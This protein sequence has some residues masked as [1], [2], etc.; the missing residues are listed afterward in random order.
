M[1]AGR[2]RLPPFPAALGHVW[3]CYSQLAGT[4]PVAPVVAPISYVEIEAFNR[5]TAAALAPWDVRLIRRIDDHVRAIV[6]GEANPSSQISVS[7]GKGVA[8]M[9]RGMAALKKKRGD[10]ARNPSASGAE[11]TPDRRM[12]R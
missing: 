9:L 7:D 10:E 5:S 12:S 3:W 4:R 11:A 8:G 1:Q 6:L 2:R